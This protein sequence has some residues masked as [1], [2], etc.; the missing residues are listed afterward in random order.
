MD[1]QSTPKPRL[2]VHLAWAYFYTN[3]IYFS[4]ASLGK[5]NAGR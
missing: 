1:E 3:F 2:W 5:I 4:L